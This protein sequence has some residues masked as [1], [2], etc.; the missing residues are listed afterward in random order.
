MVAQ[1]FAKE[2]AFSVF[3]VVDTP[4]QAV[5]AVEKISLY[6]NQQQMVYAGSAVRGR[7]RKP[8]CKMGYAGEGY[9]TGNQEPRAVP[10]ANSAAGGRL[11]N[12][13]GEANAEA[14]LSG[15]GEARR[16]LLRRSPGKQR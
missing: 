6:G 5:E 11:K 13:P 14:G 2:E 9:R 12:I 10:Q 16:T 7:D 8:V 1:K 3:T 15:R 4:R